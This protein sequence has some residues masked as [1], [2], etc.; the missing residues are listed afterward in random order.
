MAYYRY[1]KYPKKSKYY[2]ITTILIDLF[3]SEIDEFKE[4]YG[5]LCPQFRYDPYTNEEEWVKGYNLESFTKEVKSEIEQYKEKW[6]E[7]HDKNYCISA[8]YIVGIN[9]GYIFKVFDNEEHYEYIFGIDFECIES[10]VQSVDKDPGN[11]I[12]H[13]LSLTN[14]GREKLKN[15]VKIIFKG[16]YLI[17]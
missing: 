14:E 10:K 9:T 6:L 12:A 1:K 3:R 7:I 15:S 8:L 16:R 13:K 5:G 2:N 17:D 11:I 4:E